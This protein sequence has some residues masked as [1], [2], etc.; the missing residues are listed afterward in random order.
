MNHHN[1]IAALN[2]IFL[3]ILK[4][5]KDLFEMIST[6]HEFFTTCYISLKL[7]LF[8]YLFNTGRIQINKISFTRR[9]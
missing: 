6:V 4:T 7:Y 5:T 8:R 2:G 3:D 1:T 9:S